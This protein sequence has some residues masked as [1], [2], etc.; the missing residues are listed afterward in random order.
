MTSATSR[1]RATSTKIMVAQPATPS[2]SVNM[3]AKVQSMKRTAPRYKKKVVKGDGSCFFRAVYQSA[4]AANLLEKVCDALQVTCASEA[5]FIVSARTRLS[6]TIRK[7]KDGGY[8]ASTY[9]YL[10]KLDMDTYKIILDTMPDWL[11]EAFP[12]QPK[13]MRTFRRV[14][15]DSIMEQSNWVG[16]IEVDLTRALL[17]PDVRIDVRYTMLSQ[18]EEM[19]PNTVYV[20]NEGET[21]FN[22]VGVASF[23]TLGGASP[24]AARLR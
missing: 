12:E 17:A 3:S 10:S 4:R 7:N 11:S 20:I 18:A 8:V 2:N 6:D 15:S 22:G 23:A 24:N 13:S 21:H 19:E 1:K 14:L 5:E 16:Q 9:K